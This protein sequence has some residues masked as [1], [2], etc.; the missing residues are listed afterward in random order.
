M[1]PLMVEAR[2]LRKRFGSTQAVDGVD[3]AVEQGTIVAVLGPN[4]AGKSTTVRIL[5]TLTRPDAGWATVAGHDVVREPGDVRRRIGVAAQDATLDEALSGRQNLAMI[6]RLNQLPGH[7]T[8]ARSAELLERFELTDAADR[9]VRTYSG[10][11]RR[12]L[13]L[14]A[15]LM[16][17]PPMLFLDEPTTGLDPTSR[18]RVWT[19]V[20]ELVDGGTTVLLTTQYLDEA[21][22]LA[23]R[24]TIID[25]G[26]VVA[27]DT[28]AA[29]KR[30]TGG[31]ILEVRLPA[32]EPAIERVLAPFA[33][34]AI[35]VLDGGRQVRASVVSSQGL[36]APAIRLLDEAGIE[37][38]DIAVHQPSLDDVFMRLTGDRSPVEEVA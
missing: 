29:L 37:V 1:S 19:A 4:G 33:S 13:D 22:R 18:Q 17:A 16:A 28:P 15:S 30:L 35:Q 12:R 24:V 2:G 9:P 34:G 8:K 38:E 36:I 31:A 20:R 11:M 5:T 7:V 14:G 21:D 25:H 10:G 27:D 26:R 3:L 32:P 6:G 23:D